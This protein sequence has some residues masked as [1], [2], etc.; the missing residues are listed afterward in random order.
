MSE[1]RA[2]TFKV[3]MLFFV[4]LVILGAATVS[5]GNLDFLQKTWDLQVHF[6]NVGGLK[7]G[8]PVRVSGLDM[9]RVKALEL[10]PDGVLVTLRMTTDIDLK[11]DYGFEVMM[12]TLVGGRHIAVEQGTP[13]RKSVD[14]SVV[15][16][17]RAPGSAVDEIADLVRENRDSV[18]DFVAN[19]KEISESLKRG[20]G[21][22]G[23]LLKDEGLYDEARAALGEIRAGVAEV[24]KAGAVIED[25]KK[26][27]D[28][29]EGTLV[30]LLKSNEMYDDLKAT[31]E[32]LRLVVEKAEKGE[33]TIGRLLNDERLYDDARATVEQLREA[34]ASVQRMVDKVESGEGTVGKLLNDA[35]LAR[36][37][38][39]TV[40]EVRD[41]AG[42]MRSIAGKVDRGEGAIGKLVNETALYDSAKETV[43]KA[44]SALESLDKT[45]GKV[46]RVKTYVTFG[47]R[48]YAGTGVPAPTASI[49]IYPSQDRYFEVGG[50]AWIASR[51]TDHWTFPEKVEDDRGE[52]FLQPTALLGWTFMDNR[53]DLAG[54]LL[55]GKFGGRAGYRFTIPWL[56]HDVSLYGEVRGSWDDEDELDEDAG[57]IMARVY[58]DTKIWRWFHV[59]AGVSRIGE[60]PEFFGGL[61][62]RYEDEDI[63]TFIGLLGLSN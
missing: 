9:G 31:T 26:Q 25:V 36:K 23:R 8:D 21:T 7:T 20:D 62:F 14:K 53:L 34:V 44:N 46:A 24:K 38:E 22:L 2:N 28:S 54:G 12:S 51:D 60:E 43:D 47:S 29:G 13:G 3:G 27:L 33:G 49:R 45:L 61:T 30:K 17:G 1:A 5:V 32:K 15:L 40:A 52:T 63:R 50:V 19:L 11:E 37:L 16:R 10:R 48:Y 58:I 41:L 55:E 57:K 42:S 18:R 35:E 56:E 6:V 4:A 59:H 39:E